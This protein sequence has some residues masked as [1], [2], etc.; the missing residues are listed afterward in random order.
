[1]VMNLG[2]PAGES[3]K[4][5]RRRWL[6][7]ILLGSAAIGFTGAAPPSAPVADRD[8]PGNDSADAELRKV[9]EKARLAGIGPLS[10]V[11]SAHYQAIGDAAPKFMAMLV[12][13]C[14]LLALDFL[15]HF[16]ARGFNVNLPANR[17][18]IVAFLDERPFHRFFPEAAGTNIVGGYSKETNWVILFDWRNVPQRPR[19]GIANMTTL[20][21]EAMHQLCFN[22][23]LISR[24]AD[25]PLAIIEG[26]GMYAETRKLSGRSDL[27]RLNRARL[28]DLAHVLR[29]RAWIPIKELLTLDQS[30]LARDR[31]AV[32]LFY[33]E[34]WVLVY[35]LIQDPERLPRFQEYLKDIAKRTDRSHRIED[36]ETHFG[37]LDRLDRDVRAYTIRLQTG[38]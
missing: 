34:S 21:H 22:S 18:T 35:D 16:R 8:A 9:E 38:R 4:F 2:E 13:D 24:E 29:R 20:A 33:A 5:G 14:E 25:T 12:K 30:I 11:K 17:M 19:S 26:L 31:D 37:N 6:S 36:A 15:T 28:D 27:G 10:T 7:R 32:D 3:W 1:M 23:G